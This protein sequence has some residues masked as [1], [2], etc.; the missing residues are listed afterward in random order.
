MEN[1]RKFSRFT[2]GFACILRGNATKTY[3]AFLYDLSYGGAGILLDDITPF[4][5]GDVCE[6]QLSGMQ[7]GSPII[8][9]CKVVWVDSR[10]MGLEFL[11]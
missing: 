5:S 6:L 9:N 1:D 11:V 7:A 2:V 8:Y 10:K 3:K 4:Q